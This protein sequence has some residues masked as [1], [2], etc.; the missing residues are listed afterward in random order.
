MT[1]SFV[2]RP[3]FLADSDVTSLGPPLTRR[4]WTPGS[5]PTI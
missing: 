3:A 2:D 5:M 4:G 1:G